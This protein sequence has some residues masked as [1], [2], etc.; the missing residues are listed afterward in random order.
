MGRTK[1]ESKLKNRILDLIESPELHAYLMEH[2]ERLKLKDYVS[3]IAGAPISLGRKQELLHDMKRSSCLKKQEMDYVSLCCACMDRAVQFLTSETGTIFLIQLMG[4]DDKHKSDI[5][6]GPYIM[7]SLANTKNAVKNYYREDMDEDA[8][9]EWKTLYWRV[10]LYTASQDVNNGEDGF[11]S[12]EYTYIMDKDG[13]VQYY[14]HEWNSSNHLNGSLGRMVEDQFFSVS[15]DLN[16][17]V[18]YHPGDVL[19]IDCRPYAPG[20]FYCRLKEVGDDCCGIQCEYVDAEGNMETGALKH[21]DYFF[22]HREVEQYL[23]PLYR[24]RIVSK[25]ELSWDEIVRRS[26]NG[27][28]TT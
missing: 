10:E 25:Y 3:I 27:N 2:A 17:P 7:T 26:K 21:G 24:A 8:D 9:A 4:Y 22:N 14:I 11:L 20:A 16:L 18:P 19:F 5:M 23:S 6:D 12:A 1:L 28:K 15:P 13:E